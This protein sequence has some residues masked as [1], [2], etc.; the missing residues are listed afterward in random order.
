MGV[1]AGA[2]CGMGEVSLHGV[3]LFL[4]L[5]LDGVKLD[6]LPLH[7][8]E[9]CVLSTQSVNVGNNTRIPKVEQRVVHY[10]SVVG[11]WVEDTKV[12]IS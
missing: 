12:G 1:K 11:G 2:D 8:C 7:V 9:T 6:S 10:E 4:R 3:F 5:A